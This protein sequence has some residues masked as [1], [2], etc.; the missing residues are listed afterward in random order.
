MDRRRNSSIFRRLPADTDG[1]RSAWLT[2]HWHLLVTSTCRLLSHRRV[3]PSDLPEKIICWDTADD[4][5]RWRQ[6]DWKRL[7][8]EF[9]KIGT[10]LFLLGS[11]DGLPDDASPDGSEGGIRRLLLPA[12]VIGSPDSLAAVTEHPLLVQESMRPIQWV[13]IEDNPTLARRLAAVGGIDLLHVRTKSDL[14]GSGAGWAP[15]LGMSDERDQSYDVSDYFCE[16]VLS[17]MCPSA[18]EQN[19][20]NRRR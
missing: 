18:S 15:W 10:S 20:G 8:D 16:S 13:L 14:Q 12:H 17:A 1:E 9:R 11:S 5:V 19:F 4:L 7:D 3:R 6:R 2:R